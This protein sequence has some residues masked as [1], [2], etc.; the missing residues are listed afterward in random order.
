MDYFSTNRISPRVSFREAVL[1][2]QPSDKGLYFPSEI[3]RLSA[4]FIDTLADRSNEQIAFDIIR[5]Y[6]GG[7]IPDETLFEICS[8]TVN[9]SFP[10]VEISERIAVLELFHGPTLAFKDVGARFMSRCLRYFSGG[11]T[12]KT[13]V[14]VATSGVRAAVGV[15]EAVPVLGDQRAPIV[16]VD[17]PVAIVIG[18]RAAILVVERVARGRNAAGAAGVAGE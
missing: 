16:L 5:P 2:G 14:V 18:L 9:F 17:D 15:L 7:E 4:K 11:Q 10:L 3:N 6:V 1:A 13:V 8:E 12:E